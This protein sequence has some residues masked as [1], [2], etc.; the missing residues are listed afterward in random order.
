M[1]SA[2]KTNKKLCSVQSSEAG[3]EASS[4][5]TVCC[6]CCIVKCQNTNMSITISS[7]VFDLE[8]LYPLPTMCSPTLL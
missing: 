4:S 5:G 8:L 3:Q 7:V 1:E 2:I 6:M